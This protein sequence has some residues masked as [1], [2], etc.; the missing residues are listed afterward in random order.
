MRYGYPERQIAD[1]IDNVIATD[2]TVVDG[3]S[4]GDLRPVTWHRF[5]FAV[6]VRGGAQIIARSTGGS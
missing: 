6:I 2:V 3:L 5:R 1:R 4:R